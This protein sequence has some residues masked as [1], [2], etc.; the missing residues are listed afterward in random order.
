[1]DVLLYGY[2]VGL[3]DWYIVELLYCCT[4]GLLQQ[5]S[6]PTIYPYNSIYFCHSNGI[7]HL[8]IIFEPILRD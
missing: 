7:L 1:M 6:N 2:I 4:F 3:L 5:Y 8:V